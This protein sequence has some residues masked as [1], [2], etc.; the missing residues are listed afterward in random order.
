MVQECS[1]IHQIY[2]RDTVLHF[3]DN[4]KYMYTSEITIV[5]CLFDNAD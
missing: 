1:L 2:V 5:Y 4:K 3:V